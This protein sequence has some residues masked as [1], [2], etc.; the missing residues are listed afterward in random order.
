MIDL[1]SLLLTPAFRPVYRRVTRSSRFNGFGTLEAFETAL[2][3]CNQEEPGS[4]PVLIVDHVLADMVFV[5]R[6]K[7]QLFHEN[8]T[9][10]STRQLFLLIPV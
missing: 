10:S 1:R 2:H 8:N 3:L 9:C 5:G 6:L 4:S 7:L